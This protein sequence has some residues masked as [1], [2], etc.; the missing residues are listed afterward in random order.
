MQVWKM[1]LGS[2]A[3]RRRGAANQTQGRDKGASI[4]SRRG[5]KTVDHVGGGGEADAESAQ[6][7]DLGNGVGQV[8]FAQPDGPTKT[9]L[10]RSF[11]NAKRAARRTR[12]LSMLFGKVKLK[13]SRVVSG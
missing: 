4:A 8:V 13:P 10:A 9:T 3:H 2:R 11:T 6:A 12:S 7:G 5:H 1:A